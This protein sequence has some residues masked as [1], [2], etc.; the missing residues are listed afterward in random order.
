MQATDP[1]CEGRYCIVCSGERSETEERNECGVEK[2]N[3]PVEML[4][5]VEG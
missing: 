4:S 2:R 3:G 1:V 5:V